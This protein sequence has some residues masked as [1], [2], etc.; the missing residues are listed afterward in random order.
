MR[1]IFT[2]SRRMKSDAQIRY[3]LYAIGPT[4]SQIWVHGAGPG[5]PGCDEL[6]K[7]LASEFGDYVKLEPFPADWTKLGRRSAGPIR[8]SAMVAAGADICLAF[9]DNESVGTWDCLRKAVAAGIQTRI[10]PL[11][12]R[13]HATVLQ[14]KPQAK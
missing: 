6:V 10:Y 7:R 9:P 8:N 14:P 1:I 12:R 4:P 2:G 3:A 5:E 13:S 11:P